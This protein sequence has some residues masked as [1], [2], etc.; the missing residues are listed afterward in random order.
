MKKQY[1]YKT[2]KIPK[3]QMLANVLKS[4][5]GNADTLKANK[6]PKAISKEGK[7]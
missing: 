2:T 7:Q 1:I 4:K 5:S 3:A 6:P